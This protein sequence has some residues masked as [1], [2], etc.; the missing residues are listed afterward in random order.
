MSHITLD[1]Q[2]LFQYSI[3]SFQ[4]ST[5]LYIGARPLIAKFDL[6]ISTYGTPVKFK[7]LC[8]SNKFLDILKIFTISKE[9][10][11]L[12]GWQ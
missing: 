8:M 1:F 7:E 11:P 12:C 9:L 4:K 6:D 3:K 5:C 2:V 10:Q